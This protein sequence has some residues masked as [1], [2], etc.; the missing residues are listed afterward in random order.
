MA[1]TQV[2]GGMLT[3]GGV[4]SA[5]LAAGAV[6]QSNFGTN[7]AGNG[8]AFSAWQSTLQTIPSNTPTKLTFTTEEFDTNSN[9]AS[10]TF[11]P[12]VAGYYQINACCNVATSPSAVQLRIYKNGSFYKAGG[13][14]SG[15]TLYQNSVSSLVYCNGTTD[16]IEIYVIFTVGQNTENASGSTWFN[17]A[18]V[19][20]A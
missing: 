5:Q 14:S 1:L 7:V 8:P 19:R 6:A 9:Y 2:Q 10:S 11:T 20:A 12:T 4:G 16:Y 3:S 13:N 15:A 18:M 17:G